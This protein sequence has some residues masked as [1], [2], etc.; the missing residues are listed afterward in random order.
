MFPELATGDSDGAGAWWPL[1]SCFSNML[2]L[3]PMD[4]T[5]SGS[6]LDSAGGR[7]VGNWMKETARSPF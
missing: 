7:R 4:H 2:K 6:G 1:G 5:V 3:P